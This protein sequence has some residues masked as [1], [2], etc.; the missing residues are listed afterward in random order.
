MSTKEKAVKTD[1]VK[2]A[3]VETVV[4][5]KEK[6][7]KVTLVSYTIKA[8]IPTGP[9]ANVCPEITVKA[10]TIKDAENAVLPYIHE[11]ITFFRDGGLKPISTPVIT[12]V[13]TPAPKT[14]TSASNAKVEATTLRVETPV[15]ADKTA[16]KAPEDKILDGKSEPFKKAYSALKS[17][18]TVDGLD[19][20]MGQIRISK[21][22]T[23]IE[24]E[25][26]SVHYLDFLM[27]IENG[28]RAS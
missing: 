22:L 15:E 10:P 8:T 16:I 28:T 27:K 20:I 2:E 26:L 1:V 4:E 5:K 3:V 17:N 11:M 14:E 23:D 13:E 24:I 9:Y 25:E 18:K 7:P 19:V 21:R 6:K 12:K